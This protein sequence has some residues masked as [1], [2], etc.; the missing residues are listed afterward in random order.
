MS[1]KFSNPNNAYVT[2]S[3]RV[4]TKKIL[5]ANVGE[6]I[7]DILLRNYIP[8]NSVL[9][10]A[11]NQPVAENCEIIEG[12]D[13]HVKLIEG[14]DINAITK[15]YTE[16]KSQIVEAYYKK[17]LVIH[18]K[19]NVYVESQQMNLQML[20]EYV[21][22]T[23][24]ETF[25]EFKLANNGSNVLIGL[26]GG[27]D[28]SSLLFALSEM[29]KEIGFNLIA[30]TFEDFDT[31]KSPTFLNAQRITQ[32]LNVPYYLIPSS[33]INK[34][35]KTNKPLNEILLELMNTKHAH[36]VM[37]IDHHTT[38]RALEVFAARNNITEIALGLHTTDIVAGLINSHLTG[39]YI[40]DI[41]K[42]K[43]GNINYIY[44]LSYI[45]KKELHLYYYAIT[46]K[47]A[48]HSS[49]NQWELNPLDRN[50][51]YYLA[52]Q[53]Q[54]YFPGIELNLF[55]AHNLKIRKNRFPEFTICENC[56]SHILQQ[57]FELVNPALCDVC[58]IF[59]QYEYLK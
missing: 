43:I 42:R 3:D 52:D 58:N 32:Q 34:I 57:N 35:F 53:V 11:N 31:K 40:S 14:Y 17:R 5:N 28:S 48:E 23:I 12:I 4:G 29:K 44:P 33:E 13:Y 21:D 15:N 51:Y 45:T 9:I 1:I 47:F 55:E 37:Y 50:F 16:E 18:S 10:L 26:S 59:E 38:R 19:G 54:T 56:G 22:R 8:L 41:P 6:F 36:Y 39:Y 27:V 7:E 46:G 2:F 30:A 20:Q 49:P 25:Q 24:F